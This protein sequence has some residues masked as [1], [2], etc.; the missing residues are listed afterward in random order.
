MRMRLTESTNVCHIALRTGFS[1]TKLIA[2]DVE[3]P[4]VL[5]TRHEMR[6]TKK[7]RH[8]QTDDDDDDV[9]GYIYM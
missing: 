2:S 8:R 3:N 7:M 5:I 6:I 1:T 9:E 4:H